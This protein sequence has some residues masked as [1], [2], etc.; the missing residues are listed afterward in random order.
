[1]QVTIHF[2]LITNSNSHQRIRC[3]K[4]RIDFRCTFSL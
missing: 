3:K 4:S 1:M 2:L